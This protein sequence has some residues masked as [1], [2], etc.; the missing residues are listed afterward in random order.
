MM[1]RLA[2]AQ[3]GLD[4][5][6]HPRLLQLVRQ[7]VQMRAAGE[8][9]LLP[10]RV[11]VVRFDRPR[12]VPPR[13]VV[14]TRPRAQRVHQPRLAPRLRPHRIL[15][16]RREAL[17]RLLRV[18][19]HQRP[20]LRFREVAHANRLRR[21]V[22]RAAAGDDLAGARP[23][24]VVADV[25]HAAQHHALREALGALL[26]AGAELAQ[27][28][29]QG[30]ADQRVDLVHQ[31]HQRRRV[32]HAPAGEQPLQ[33]VVRPRL[34]Q[35]VRPDPVRVV[36]AQQQRALRQVTQNG[37]DAPRRVVP[38]HL[39]DLDVHVHAAEI[40][41][42]AAVEK[43]AQGDQGGSL[44]RLPRR[45]QREVALGPNQ[46]QE[47][48]DIHPIQRLDGVVIV[49][50]HRPFGVEE[51]HV[52]IIAL[53]V[54]RCARV[55]KQS[56][57]RFVQRG[58]RLHCAERTPAPGDGRRS[59]AAKSSASRIISRSPAVASQAVAYFPVS[60]DPDQRRQVSTL[61]SA[62]SARSGPWG[63]SRPRWI[64]S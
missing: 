9:K 48:V 63:P 8:D 23:D 34:G 13:L 53:A 52:P 57:P 3:N 7:L 11:D 33:C 26:V 37:A 31:Q 6:P 38:R 46:V 58:D 20:R 42:F 2:A 59:D 29:E 39:T 16:R 36:V 64:A 14:E 32:R 45:V 54:H 25:A 55:R 41:G 56:P 44:A 24:A 61:L 27:H 17:A 4:D 28:R 1:P 15:R 60:A 21:N 10:R 49:R 47:F 30:V 50:A 12:A 62:G 35:N 43:V 40:A 18:L 22:E 5:P 51:A 19:R